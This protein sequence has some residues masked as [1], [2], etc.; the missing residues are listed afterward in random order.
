MGYA[1]SGVTGVSRGAWSA[2]GAV[3]M[4]LR[5]VWSNQRY[6]RRMERTGRGLDEVVW[7]TVHGATEWLTLSFSPP[8]S[9]FSAKRGRTRPTRVWP[10][11]GKG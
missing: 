9:S 6:A 8:S 7:R 3:W 2:L 4:T 5:V 1:R 11:V 10:T